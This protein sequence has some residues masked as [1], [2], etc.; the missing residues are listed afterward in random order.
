MDKRKLVMEF[1]NIVFEANTDGEFYIHWNQPTEQ[2]KEFLACK[3][4]KGTKTSAEPMSMG[5]LCDLMD[6]LLHLQRR[7]QSFHIAEV[8]DFKRFGL[9]QHERID[10]IFTI[11]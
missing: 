7:A 1:V 8:Y 10:L 6:V 2:H 4:W 3:I 9:N 5:N 11:D